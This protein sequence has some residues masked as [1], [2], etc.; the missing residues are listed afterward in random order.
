MPSRRR[1]RQPCARRCLSPP[2]NRSATQGGRHVLDTLESALWAFENTDSLEEA[3][4]AAV[5]RGGDADT[6]GAVVGALAG[7]RYGED[8]IPE[9][10][11]DLLEGS[12]E[13]AN[14]AEQLLRIGA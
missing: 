9:R 7:A 13:I 3:L 8:A 5:N 14:L 2:T 4:V 10:W 1:P 6:R 11:L 12:D